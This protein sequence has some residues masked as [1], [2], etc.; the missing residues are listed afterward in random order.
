MTT[1]KNTATAAKQADAAVKAGA[2]AFQ[3]YEEV[4]AFAKDTVEAVMESSTILAKGVQEF[5]K[6]WFD[7]AQASV[8]QN[9]A[10]TKAL[11]GCKSVK[12]LAEVQ[13]GLVA[14]NYDVLVADSRK[15][16]DMS[17]KL[18]EEAAKPVNARVNAAMDRLSKS[19]AV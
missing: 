19:V 7:L 12:E 4:V 2:D 6:V 3:G 13:S 10:A 18:A 15:L 9:V 14:K 8:E 17:V 1:R 5:N 16:S 11:L